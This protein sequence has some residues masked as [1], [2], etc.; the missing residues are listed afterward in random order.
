MLP[1]NDMK[2]AWYSLCKAPSYAIT[3]ILSIGLP[4]SMLLLVG[5]LNYH[6]LLAPLAY[7]NSDQLMVIKGQLLKGGQLEVDET[8]SYPAL[9]LLYQ[10]ALSEPSTNGETLL[11]Y[12][13]ELVQNLAEKPYVT[14]SY[15]TPLYGE[16]FAVP[17]QL[18]RF[19]HTAEGLHR[20]A[21]VAIISH[22]SWL[23][24]FQADPKV[25]ERTVV[26]NGHA[27][28]IIGV[29]AAN[30]QEPK[31]QG[32]DQSSTDLWLPF[33]FKRMP[34]ADRQ[35]WGRTFSGFYLLAKTTGDPKLL[36][37]AWS[38]RLNQQH[39]QET[40][41]IEQL[42]PF[43]IRVEMLA[44]KTKL[45]GHSASLVLLLLCSS[46]IFVA[47]A[48]SNAAHLVLTRA[49]RLAPHLAITAALGASPHQVR[50]RLMA[51]QLWLMAG[52]ILFA[53]AMALI[54]LP[55]IRS[56]VA[57]YV[58]HSDLLRLS[59][60]SLAF[61][62]CVL[63]GLMLIFSQILY[64]QC[65]YQRLSIGL[66]TGKSGAFQYQSQRSRRLLLTQAALA[67][68][69][70]VGSVQLLQQSLQ[71]VKQ[72]LGFQ[73]AQQ[74]LVE[75]HDGEGLAANTS[76]HMADWLAIRQHL[77]QQ[78]G[79]GMVSITTAPPIHRF[80]A[81]QWQTNI[82]LDADF[83]SMHRVNGARID[84][85]FIPTLGIP[86]RAGRNVSAQD[87]RTEAKVVII[88]QT[89]AQQLFPAQTLQ[90]II[91]QPI[92]WLN[93]PDSSQPYEV[94]GIMADL[95]IPGTPETGR[96]LIPKV[97]PS[98]SVLLIS[99]LAAT[100]PNSMS[101][102]QI[103]QWL[104]QVRPRYAVTRLLSLEHAH[105]QLVAMDIVTVVSTASLCLLV[106]MLTGLGMFGVLSYSAQL[107]RNELGIRMALGAS[108]SNI[109][110][111]LL[112]ENLR[113]VLC[114]AMIAIVA[115]TLLNVSGLIQSIT[116]I[117]PVNIAIV[118][119]ILLLITLFSTSLSVWHTLRQPASYALQGH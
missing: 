101:T 103:N 80:G 119:I 110:R 77:K 41:S 84:E 100:T 74:Y 113:P 27:F 21:P 42:H 71:H 86:L 19:F 13:A 46:V 112:T 18:G 117:S 96:L 30:F 60:H 102:M 15:V 58:A 109:L 81:D 92:Y 36:S 61:T 29:T 38:E 64:R 25:L 89:L 62:L 48:G 56:L 12:G 68:L 5:A 28:Q 104:H 94:V 88:N 8:I 49:A 98:H 111:Q 70:L 93:S 9:Q 20:Q 35:N 2:M 59:W 11:A 91:G 7:P 76:Q 1:I 24:D 90:N 23:R 33:D 107:R 72:P 34:L 6:V 52:S 17:M 57:P 54:V 39:Q 99:M 55:L 44:L 63:I 65:H 3:L 16:L 79:V 114:G 43:S 40:Q 73:T 87:V 50:A 115:M 45:N 51:E 108:P 105:Q 66:T 85:Y 22:Q 69:L 118:L 67:T 82:S 26:L 95:S 32:A 31:L 106:V 78:A 10:E 4:L 116:A 14:T 97:Q 83:Q 47:A 75:L 37:Q 53:I